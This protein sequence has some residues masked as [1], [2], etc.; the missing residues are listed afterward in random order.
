MSTELTPGT[1]DAGAPVADLPD[2]PT[3][4]APE[5]PDLLVEIDAASAAG[6]DTPDDAA[7]PLVITDTPPGPEGGSGPGAG[8]PDGGER[9]VA[10]GRAA[11]RGVLAFTAALAVF[12][13]FLWA[14]GADPLA[15]YQAM[16]S[17]FAGDSNSLGELAVQSAPFVLAALA[18]AIPARA[19]LFNIGGEGQLVL[20]AIGGL[21]MADLLGNRFTP[22]IQLPL[23]AVG[24]MLGGAAWALIPALLKRYAAT[25]EAIT[26]LLLNYI[27]TL[28]LAWLVHGPW[29]DT[30]S[31][32]FPQS[33]SL[34]MDERFP[35]LDG[36]RLHA[37]V[38]ISVVVAVGMWF[39]L[40]AT[41]W[42]FRLRVVGGNAEAARRAGFRVGAITISAM[43]VGGALAGLAGMIEL[44]GVEGQLRP[45]MLVG[46]GFIGFL[47][48]WLVRHDPLKILGSALLMG[49][50]AVG[51]NGLKSSAGLS[52]AA[53]YVLMA[54]LLL[55]ILGWGTRRPGTRKAVR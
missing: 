23:M 22:A 5:P 39:I 43:L 20:G 7:P 4:A 51:S 52:G 45:S 46:Y 27:A 31:L 36:S 24:G 6:V 38:L 49:A 54:V 41:P 11:L 12:A 47:A 2:V 26:S 35:L 15:T 10:A 55:A 16:W 28:L 13:V 33:R 9:L 19:G 42:G 21:M 50:L 18:V 32:G 37:G 14:K 29:K 8:G 53:V 1:P 44:S 3:V 25:S 48:S 34:E 40:R 17:A 30:S